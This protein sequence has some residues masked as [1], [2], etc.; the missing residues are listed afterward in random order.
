MT[1]ASSTLNKILIIIAMT[2]AYGMIFLD[3]TGVAVV[4]S[5]LQQ[6]LHVSNNILHWVINGYLLTMAM[7]QLVGGKLADTYGHRKIF[8]LGLIIFL[9]ASVVCASAQGEWSILIGRI[10]QGI[11]A[12]LIMPTV[13]VLV[14]SNFPDY[15]YG[16]AFGT[17]LGFANLFY[18]LGPFIGGTFAQFLSWRW[19]FWINIPVGVV[20]LYC[21][22][23]ALAKDQIST[24]YSS[25][26]FKGLF[27]FMIT[28]SALIIA[29][30]QGSDAGWT[31]VWILS[32]FILT[33][34]S[35][36]F[37]IKIELQNTH[38]LLPLHL[39]QNKIFMAGNVILS[40]GYG[41]LAAIPFLAIWLHNAFGFSPVTVGIAMLP[42]TATIFMP[43]LSG[44]WRDKSGP[45][46]PMIAGT[47]LTIF[48]IAW[49]I[50]TASTRNYALIFWGLLAFGIGLPLVIPN[51]VTTI[52][53]SVKPEQRGIASGTFS[54]LRLV[55][56]SLGFALM[57]AVISAYDSAHPNGDITIIYSHAFS[58]GMIPIGIFAIIACV[59]TFIFIP[60]RGPV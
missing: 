53:T 18:A 30:M 2:V 50:I 10:L 23:L 49:I 3:Q 25:F 13:A 1:T 58:Y 54:T 26:D 43:P 14:N 48:S 17:I 24:K 47:C 45:R 7:L 19:I 33:I 44:M 37:F 21:A 4:L 51:G 32:L 6:S 59:F 41:C 55:A 20:S 36:V 56:A 15:E 52:M 16:K 5:S 46:P 9:I 60:K 34:I 57:G 40:C 42:A 29:L 27:T 12:S 35:L 22:Y 39:F 11:G 38:P 31:N 28:V 8:L